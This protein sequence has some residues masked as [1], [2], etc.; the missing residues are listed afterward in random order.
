MN[1]NKF[2]IVCAYNKHACTIESNVSKFP[3]DRLPGDLQD[4]ICEHTATVFSV[5]AESTLRLRLQDAGWTAVP[6]VIR[7]EFAL[8]PR[9][10]YLRT[11]PE[12]EVTV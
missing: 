8:A 6:Y 1:S 9:D 3:W 12:F 10:R 5:E 11:R 7:Y 2:E 4:L